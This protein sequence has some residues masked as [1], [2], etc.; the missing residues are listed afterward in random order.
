MLMVMMLMRLVMVATAAMLIMVMV[1]VLVLLVM[2]AA[3]AVLV[4]LMVMVLVFLVV[5]ATA[6]MLI[7]VMVM[8]MVMLLLQLCKLCSQ[9]CLTFHGR[10]Q[11]LTGQLAPRSGDQSSLL[12]MLPDQG[13][14]CIQLG[15]RHGIGTGENDGGG[16]LDLVV[17]ELTEILHIDFDLACVRNGNGVAQSD[18]LAGDLLHSCDNIGQLTNTGGFNDHPVRMELLNNFRQRLAEIAHEG[19][20]NAAGVHFRNVDAGI[21]KETAVDADLTEFIFDQHQLL[22]LVGFLNHLL[23][24]SGLA[25]TKETGKYIDLCH[26]KHLLFL[27]FH[28]ILYHPVSRVTSKKSD[29]TDF[30]WFC[31]IR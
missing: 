21:L 7:M 26:K 11:L 28:P 27:K 20:A 30:P 6:A 15:L 17:V 25:G 18:F 19:A 22:A 14:G 4:M 23:D 1:M 31:R 13:N 9:S 29:S 12:V 8:V 5:V 3:A 10:D 16:S 24:Q 2:V